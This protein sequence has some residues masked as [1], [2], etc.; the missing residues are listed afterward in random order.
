MDEAEWPRSAE[1]ARVPTNVAC[2]SQRTRGMR[3]RTKALA[4]QRLKNRCLIGTILESERLKAF[5]LSRVRGTLALRR[6]EHPQ[7]SS[8]GLAGTTVPTGK[9]AV[10]L[11]GRRESTP[12]R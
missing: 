9:A 2:T 1:C 12:G 10:W 4:D 5:D 8:V 7:G 11:L 3:R 6:S